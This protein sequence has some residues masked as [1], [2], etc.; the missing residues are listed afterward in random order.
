MSINNFYSK[1]K[2]LDFKDV[3]VVPQFSQLNSRRQVVLEKTIKFK[4]GYEWNGIPI[5]AANMTT[6]GT[7]EVYNILSKQKIITALHKFYK[8]KDFQDYLIENTL[9]PNYFMISTDRR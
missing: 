2:Y 3:L 4:N 8:Y 9:D 6:T 7:F 1:E 5:V